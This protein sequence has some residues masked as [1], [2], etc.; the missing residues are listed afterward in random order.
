MATDCASTSTGASAP[1]HPSTETCLA[2]AGSKSV[3]RPGI[4]LNRLE[5]LTGVDRSSDSVGTRITSGG[6]S[7]WQ[8]VAVTWRRLCDVFRI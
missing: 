7:V 4:I 8:L 1:P 2:A 5:S 6:Y 3:V